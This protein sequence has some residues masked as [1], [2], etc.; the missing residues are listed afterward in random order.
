LAVGIVYNIMNGSSTFNNGWIMF[1]GFVI[2]GCL[3]PLLG[4]FG[5]GAVSKSSRNKN[6]LALYLITGLVLVLIELLLGIIAFALRNGMP[7]VTSATW[8][9][10]FETNRDTLLQ[11]ENTYS[12][13][14]WE[15]TTDRA[16]PPFT[17]TDNNTCIEWYPTFANLS[18]DGPVG[19][20]FHHA[21]VIAGATLLP[22]A[23]FQLLGLGI[24]ARLFFVLS[25][26]GEQE[27]QSLLQGEGVASQSYQTSQK[28]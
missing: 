13:C 18:C 25:W 3:V 9:D 14:G 23:F 15:N 6:I 4:F 8:G 20:V 16:V 7:R 26:A 27:E 12:C 24:S 22:L 5:C 11:I 17:E 19:E 1:Y 21:A 10:L 2:L 28:N